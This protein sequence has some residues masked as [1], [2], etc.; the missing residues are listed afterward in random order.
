M[1][2]SEVITRTHAHTQ[3]NRFYF[4]KTE[5]FFYIDTQIQPKLCVI[6]ALPTPIP[7]KKKKN[8]EKGAAR[9]EKFIDTA[10][11]V[12][13]QNISQD[14][15]TALVEQYGCLGVEKGLKHSF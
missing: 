10:T 11:T 6:C 2:K 7:I 12:V 1:T 14:L 13:I 5:H 9:T 4:T 8:R 3:R 15:P